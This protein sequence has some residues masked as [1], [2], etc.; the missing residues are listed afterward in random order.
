MQLQLDR[1]I[2]RHRL[3]IKNVFVSISCPSSS[4]SLVSYS[5]PKFIYSI[6]KQREIF[7]A[8]ALRVSAVTFPEIAVVVAVVMCIH[9]HA[10]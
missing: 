2:A 7:L 5:R 9:L 1:F 8:F 3:Q 6:L 4:P 10:I